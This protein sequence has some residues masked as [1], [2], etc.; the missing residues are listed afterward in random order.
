MTLSR[1]RAASHGRQRLMES[2]M[3]RRAE[4]GRLKGRLTAHRCLAGDIISVHAPMRERK[5][6]PRT[7][8]KI[9][10]QR[11]PVAELRSQNGF[12]V[13]QQRRRPL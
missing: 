7:M 6:L 4:Q 11:A 9:W 8:K 10:L 3:Q 2:S 5:S 13:A 12:A 1:L